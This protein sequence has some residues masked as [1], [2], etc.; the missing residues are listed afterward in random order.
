MVF[1]AIV[2]TGKTTFARNLF[3]EYPENVYIV[4]NCGGNRDF[5][6]IIVNAIN[7]GSSSKSITAEHKLKTEYQA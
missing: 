5:S 6:T 7:I 2:N 4:D 1:D 3:I